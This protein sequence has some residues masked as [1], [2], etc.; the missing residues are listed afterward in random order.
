MEETTIESNEHRWNTDDLLE[1][2]HINTKE[3]QKEQKVIN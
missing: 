2:T 1:Y 3:T